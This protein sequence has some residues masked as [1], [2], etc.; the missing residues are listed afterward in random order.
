MENVTKVL[1]T[2][3]PGIRVLPLLGNHDWL[4]KS[5]LPPQGETGDLY[6]QFATLFQN[7]GWLSAA[8]ATVFKRG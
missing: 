6:D 7:A 8:E 3:F 4:P 5:K 2:Q 1:T